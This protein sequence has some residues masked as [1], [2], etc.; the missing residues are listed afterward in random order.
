MHKTEKQGKPKLN[1]YIRALKKKKKERKEK[2][3]RKGLEH[4]IS[5]HKAPQLDFDRS[6]QSIYSQS[7]KEVIS[8]LGT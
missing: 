4:Y 7:N 8:K 1:K 3:K 6:P 2:R 5:K